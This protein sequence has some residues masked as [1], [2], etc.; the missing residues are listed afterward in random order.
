MPARR[1]LFVIRGKLGDS[2]VLYAMV[3]AYIQAHPQDQV[4][5]LIRRDYALLL[6]H[7]KIL[8]KHHAFLSR[9]LCLPE[10]HVQMAGRDRLLHRML[11]RLMRLCNL[12]VQ[13][14]YLM[15]YTSHLKLNLLE[16]TLLALLQALPD[17]EHCRE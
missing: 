17:P 16:R 3:R 14:F 11:S 10:Q 4:S 8:E 15:Q 5:L 6:K 9:N 7:E 13:L 12:G 1:I 2:L